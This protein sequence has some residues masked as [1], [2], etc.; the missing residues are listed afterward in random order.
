MSVT[1]IKYPALHVSAATAELVTDILV[2]YPQAQIVPRV[3]PLE[4]E[5]ISVEVRLPF[6]REGIYQARDQ[7][8]AIVIQLQEQYD[9]LILA[10]AVPA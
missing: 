1:A 9:V 5:D 10:S 8:H 2:L 4:D 6:D 7:I 3:T